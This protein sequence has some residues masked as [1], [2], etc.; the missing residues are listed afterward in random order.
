MEPVVMRSFLSR[1]SA[2]QLISGT[3][4]PSFRKSGKLSAG[5]RRFRWMTDWLE[6]SSFSWRTAT[7]TGLTDDSDECISARAGIA[8]RRGNEGGPCSPGIRLVHPRR[9]GED[10]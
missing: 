10:L 1:P 3:T 8:A 2:R 6:H 7:S 4:I 5:H 9:A